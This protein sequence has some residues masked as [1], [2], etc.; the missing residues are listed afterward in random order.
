[1]ETHENVSSLTR[2]DK[3]DLAQN[4]EDGG[5]QREGACFLMEHILR[6]AT[7]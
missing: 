6:T 1:M 4:M 3:V 5:P 7:P 2:N